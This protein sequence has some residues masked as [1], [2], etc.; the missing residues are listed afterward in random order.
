MTKTIFILNILIAASSLSGCLNAD[1]FIFDAKKIDEY[2]LPDNTIPMDL[3][4]AIT[5]KSGDNTLYG[6][7]IK[8]DPAAAPLPY[9]LLYF[10]GNQNNI[11]I[12]WE[13]MMRLH[14]TG[15]AVVIFDYRGY[16]KS[17]G[18]STSDST[19]YADS[20]AAL[21]FV[22]SRGV[23]P[24][25]LCL[26]GYSLGNVGMLHVASS[27]NTSFRC[28]ITHSGFASIDSLIQS[29]T[30]LPFPDGWLN[31]GNFDNASAIKGVTSPILVLHGA[32]DE[33][34]RYEDNG[35]ILFNNAPQPKTLRK[36]DGGGH[37]N[38]PETL[39]ENVYVQIILSWVKTQQLP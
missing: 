26:H 35:L 32:D 5:F 6:Y 9:T 25:D 10:H 39:G 29:G 30:F 19:L 31:K 18:E 34:A 7:W 13:E 12:F 27:S 17:E 1:A 16:G 23:Q 36:V 11:D 8:P 24:Q 38:I 3:I 14:K 20:E 22:L 21:A 37:I 4:E 2:E 33:T 15:A 28:V